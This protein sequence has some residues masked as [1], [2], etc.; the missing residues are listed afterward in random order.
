MEWHCLPYYIAA[1]EYQKDTRKRIQ[2]TLLAFNKDD[3]VE[4]VATAPERVASLEKQSGDGRSS[5]FYWM[6]KATFRPHCC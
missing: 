1:F 4:V 2:E 6:T 3:L 5:S